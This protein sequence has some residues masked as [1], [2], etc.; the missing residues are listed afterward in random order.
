MTT[1]NEMINLSGELISAGEDEAG[2][3]ALK[4]AILMEYESYTIEK[5]AAF[6]LG[7]QYTMILV[8]IIAG[9]NQLTQ[10]IFKEQNRLADKLFRGA[11]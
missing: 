5:K 9:N 6:L 8:R 1:P 11:Q 2:A 4:S 3:Q 10:D 7:S